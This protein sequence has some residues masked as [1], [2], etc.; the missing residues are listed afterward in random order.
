MKH[1]IGHRRR[2]I[3]YEAFQEADERPWWR[4]VFE[5]DKW[6]WDEDREGDCEDD[7]DDDDDDNFE[8]DDHHNGWD[9]EEDEEEWYTLRFSRWPLGSV[10]AVPAT[11]STPTSLTSGGPTPRAERQRSFTIV[12]QTI[13]GYR[14]PEAE[15]EATLANQ[16]LRSGRLDATGEAKLEHVPD[17]PVFIRYPNMDDVSAKA[18]AVCVRRGLEAKNYEPVYRLLQRSPATIQMAVRHYERYFNDY[19]GEGFVQDINAVFTDPDARRVIGALLA[20]AGIDAGG[21]TA[22]FAWRAQDVA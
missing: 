11:T 20:R 1:V 5:E 8:C 15:F 4:R 19:T 3:R 6:D 13:E 12:L 9:G 21:A 18:L 16:E 17:G 2:L 7:D 22:Q 10:P 14:I